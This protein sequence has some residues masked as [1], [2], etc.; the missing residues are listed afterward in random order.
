MPARQAPP[1]RSNKHQSAGGC[2]RWLCGV[3]WIQYFVAF[4][5]L[6]RHFCHSYTSDTKWAQVHFVGWIKK[7]VNET[8]VGLI[9]ILLMLVVNWGISAVK[10]RGE[11]CPMLYKHCWSSDGVDLSLHWVGGGGVRHICYTDSHNVILLKKISFQ[12]LYTCQKAALDIFFFFFSF[13]RFPFTCFWW[14]A[15]FLFFSCDTHLKKKE[16]KKKEI[17]NVFQSLCWCLQHSLTL[18]IC[19][20]Y[21]FT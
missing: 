16:K 6:Q 18:G 13:S 11:R 1:Q 3:W 21:I 5:E 2:S 17:F 12:N 20:G 10:H 8:P 19:I 14:N 15:A 4:P 9:F 7:N